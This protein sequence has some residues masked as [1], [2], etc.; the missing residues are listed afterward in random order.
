MTT[1]ERNMQQVGI[2][3]IRATA[4]LMLHFHW[5]GM[6]LGIRK[7]LLTAKQI[8]FT[9]RGDDFNIGVQCISTQLKT[10]LVITLASGTM[11]NRISI[12]FCS[13]LNQTLGNQ[14]TCNRSTEQILALIYRVGAEHGEHEITHKLFAQVINIDFFN[15]KFFS[16]FACRFKLFTLADIGGKSHYLTLVYIL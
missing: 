9:P 1:F 14:W 5:N 8:P 7:Q 3:G 11:R 6:L 16:F 4:L 13:N 10:H 12:S 2:H 15:T